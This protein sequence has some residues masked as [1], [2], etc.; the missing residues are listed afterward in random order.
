MD[1]VKLN[2]PDLAD[3]VREFIPVFNLEDVIDDIKKALKRASDIF[4]FEF[5]RF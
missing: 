1:R 5:G 4:G 3:I 2:Y